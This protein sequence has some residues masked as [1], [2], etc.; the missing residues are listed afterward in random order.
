MERVFKYHGCGN[1]F[2]VVDRRATGEDIDAPRARA[3]CDRR[4]GIG[5]DGVLVLLPSAKGR[6]RMVVHNA[7]G[8]IPEMCGNGIRC[9]AKFLADRD[10][11][12]P[13]RLP[14]ETGAGVLDCAVHYGPDRRAAE[15]EVQMGP[16]RLLAP[17]LPSGATGRAFV[18]ELLPGTEVRGTAV[19]MGNPHLVLFGYAPALAGTLGPR[20]ELHPSFP[21]KTN[22]EFC[23]PAPGGYEVAVWERGVGLTQACGTGA[24]AVIAAA[25]HQQKLPA[26]AWHRVALPGGAL[27]I[28]V[29]AD[30]SAVQMR[31]PATFVFEALV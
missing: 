15:I 10:E 22:V 29:A 2:V 12:H 24:C 3:L 26:E 19:S 6:A 20:L 25:V 23:A 27:S 8:S 30:L 11:S 16:A 17:H 7:D 4:T 18:D 21:E 5:G 28:R 14:I 9:V 13:D 31:G 1:D